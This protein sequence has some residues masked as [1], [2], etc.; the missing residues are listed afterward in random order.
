[1]TW[2][3]GLV[4]LRA[5]TTLAAQT[6]TEQRGGETWGGGEGRRRCSLEF[7]GELS[8]FL[9]EMIRISIVIA[10]NSLWNSFVGGTFWFEKEVSLAVQS[11]TSRIVFRGA[12]SRTVFGER[13]DLSRVVF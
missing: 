7:R 9:L 1:M 5:R 2:L 6:S 11:I 8:L 13:E 4:C 3:S 12:L 10:V